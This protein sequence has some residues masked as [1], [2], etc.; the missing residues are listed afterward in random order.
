MILFY[1]TDSISSLNTLMFSPSLD[2]FTVKKNCFIFASDYF[3]YFLTISL[4]F[5]FPQHTHTHTHTL[6]LSLS[7][8]SLSLSLSL[9]ESVY[10][11]LDLFLS[12]SLS[13]SR[14]FSISLFL[15]FLFDSLCSWRSHN[16]FYFFSIWKHSF[17]YHFFRDWSFKM[18]LSYLSLR[19]SLNKFPDF[20]FVWALL[21]IVHTWNSSPLRSYLLRLQCTCWTVPTISERPHGSPLVCASQWPSSQP[22]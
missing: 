17:F 15:M 5:Y 16:L 2:Y 19:G 21:L 8:S 14:S 20:F 9:S 3:F 12:L 22:L 7:L 18:D 10:I 11:C 1:L 13:P 4:P 6:S